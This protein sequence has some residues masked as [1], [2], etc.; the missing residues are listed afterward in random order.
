M[1]NL[2]ILGD[3]FQTIMVC[4]S[5]TDA[6]LLPGETFQCLKVLEDVVVNVD[7]SLKQNLEDISMI[8]DQ[9]SAE[10]LYL[11]G[12]A[13]NYR[14]L[15]THLRKTNKILSHLLRIARNKM[16]NPSSLI[17]ISLTAVSNYHLPTYELPK[18]LELQ[19]QEVE[20]KASNLGDTMKYLED[21]V[22]Q[23]NVKVLVHTSDFEI[24][25]DR[26]LE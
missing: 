20:E 7:G 1:L 6:N 24:D 5:Q 12:L 25:F 15:F 22:I 11:G 19:L 10:E 3:F 4:T 26:F 14:N 9:L 17:E 23:L 2:F 13:E 16:T 21:E 8:F 18:E